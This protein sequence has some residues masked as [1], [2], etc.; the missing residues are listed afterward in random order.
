MSLVLTKNDFQLKYVRIA[1]LSNSYQIE[2]HRKPFFFS[3][4]IE[5]AREIGLFMRNKY[6]AQMDIKSSESKEREFDKNGQGKNLFI[7]LPTQV[8]S[9]H[10]NTLWS[11]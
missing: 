5:E 4:G 10:Q 1:W 7:D 6:E 11:F 9:K 2:Y 8:M 3:G